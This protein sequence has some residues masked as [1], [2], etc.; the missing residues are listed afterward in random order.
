M[1]HSILR[2]F[3][4]CEMQLDASL[5]AP[6]PEQGRCRSVAVSLQTLALSAELLPHCTAKSGA[7]RE[8]C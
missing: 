1:L 3:S 4:V 6:V 5:H 7:R 8:F 2:S